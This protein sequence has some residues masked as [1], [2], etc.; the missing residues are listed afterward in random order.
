MRFSIGFKIFGIAVFLAVVMFIAA[1]LSEM[2]VRQAEIRIDVLADHLIPMSEKSSELRTLAL[3]ETIRFR[4]LLITEMQANT[5]NGPSVS[6]T[7]N[8]LAETFDTVA[9]EMHGEIDAAIAQLPTAD[10]KVILSDVR[11]RLEALVTAHDSLHFLIQRIVARHAE[12]NTPAETE[13]VSLFELQEDTF[14]AAHGT[15]VKEIRTVVNAVAKTA[16]EDQALAIS[17]EHVVTGVAAILGL[18]LA[19][20]M[21]RAL[22]APIRNLRMASLAVQAGDLTQHVDIKGNDELADLSGTF[23]SMVEQLR[24]KE[25]TEAVFGRYVD[26]RVIE[27]LVDETGD[28]ADDLAAAGKQQATIFFSDIAGYTTISEHLTPAGLVHLMNEYFNMAGEPIAATSGLL[29]KFIGD[30]VMAFWCP[31]FAPADDIAR[32]ACKAV[33]GEAAMMQEFQKRV[34]DITGIRVGAPTINIRMGLATGEVVVGSIGSANKRNFTVIG[35]TVNL[36]S[37]LEG[38][39]KFYGTQTLICERTHA[40]MGEG[41]TTR[42]IDHLAVV[43]KSEA[44]RIYELFG[45]GSPSNDI[46][47]AFAAFAAGLSFYRQSDWDRATAKFNECLK[48]KPEDAPA[49]AFLKRIDILKAQPLDPAWN[50][51][52]HLHEK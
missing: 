24:R 43:G 4:N 18:L 29:D 50:G 52:W 9:K 7:Y 35:D 41:F 16:E 15:L 12:G 8:D 47:D 46:A 11:I 14:A 48:A 42:E 34:P 21:T 33:I 17:F 13:L 2:R 22:I 37:R 28:N 31:P 25:K 19:G 38:A 30:A 40:M 27:K 51:I 6:D 1:F 32:L 10:R 3:Q 45:A 26:P 36:S 5:T 44:V 49:R 39:N 23:N 20:I